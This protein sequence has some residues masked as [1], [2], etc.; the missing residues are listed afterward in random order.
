M[1]KAFPCLHIPL[2][3]IY[4]NSAAAGWE[5]SNISN[6]GEGKEQALFSKAFQALLKHDYNVFHLVCCKT[7]Q[8]VGAVLI[9]EH[10]AGL[11]LLPLLQIVFY[12]DKNFQGRGHE[13]STD[14]PD[15]SSYL[16]SC[17]SIKVESGCWVLYERPNYTGY[18]YMLSP[19]EYPDHQ[20][21]MGFNNSIKSC[22]SIKNVSSDDR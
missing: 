4:H 20:H 6:N 16:S 19:G 15:L 13:C 8:Y 21:W 2:F 11:F 5:A 14:S 17:N 1:T 3:D 9:A 10:H 18:Q 22:R 12:K 7:R